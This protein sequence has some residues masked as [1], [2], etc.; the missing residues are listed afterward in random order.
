LHK[1]DVTIKHVDAAEYVVRLPK[2]GKLLSCSLNSRSTEPLLAEDGGLIFS[3]P[4][5]GGVN[6]KS[7]VSYVFTAKGAKMNPVEG[8]AQLELPRTPLFIHRLTWLVQLPNE[9]QAT[10][11]EGN[12]VIDVGGANGKTVRLIKQICDDETPYAS[13]YYTRRDLQN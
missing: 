8:K 2:G 5:V 6:P 3:L 4:K 1:A 10:A 12:V 13:L 9:Y 7:V 11:L